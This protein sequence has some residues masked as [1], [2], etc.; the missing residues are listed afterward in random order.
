MTNIAYAEL[1]ELRPFFSTAFAHLRAMRPPS[2]LQESTSAAPLGLE[3]SLLA[4]YND[5]SLG[6]GMGSWDRSQSQ[7]MDSFS[8]NA[9][10]SGRSPTRNRRGNRTGAIDSSLDQDSMQSNHRGVSVDMQDSQDD[11]DNDDGM[12]V[13]EWGT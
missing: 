4:S 6:A 11:D 5:E 3:A 2:Q 7:E 12:A 8:N 9:Y 1:C 13:A 10:S